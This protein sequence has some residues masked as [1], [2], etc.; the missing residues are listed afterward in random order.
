MKMF[1]E[2]T[3]TP[4]RNVASQPPPFPE[5]VSVFVAENWRAKSLDFYNPPPQIRAPSVAEPKQLQ[6]HIEYQYI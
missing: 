4:G 6:I 5:N 2:T 1:T 3:W